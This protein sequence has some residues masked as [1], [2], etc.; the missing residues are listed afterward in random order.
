MMIVWCNLQ[1]GLTGR[2]PWSRGAVTLE[3][4]RPTVSFQPERNLHNVYYC[5]VWWCS[6]RPD[7]QNGCKATETFSA[8][9]GEWW[10][11]WGPMRST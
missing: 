7:A 4:E 9:Y 5:M 6:R 11:I 2:V 1:A 10:G 3:S 8:L